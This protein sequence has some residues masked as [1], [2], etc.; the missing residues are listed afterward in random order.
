MNI[1]ERIASFADIDTRRALG[2]PP[3]KLVLPDLN[4]P[5]ITQEYF[6]YNQGRSI[7]IKLRNAHL[8]IGP[9]DISW[10]IGTDD[11]K[12]SRSYSFGRSDGIVSY[13]ALLVMKQSRHP[14]FMR[15]WRENNVGTHK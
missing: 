4:L 14:D 12:T 1:I 10:V 11:F 13:Y 9:L 5:F 15:S 2:V 8:Y 7:F 6:E 3:R